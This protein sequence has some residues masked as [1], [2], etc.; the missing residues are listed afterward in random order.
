MR[1]LSYFHGASIPASATLGHVV[2][3]A[4]LV[5]A[6]VVDVRS[7]RIPNWLTGLGALLGL[8]WALLPGGVPF[9]SALGAGLAGMLLLLPMYALGIM[10]AGDAKL[11]GMA[12]TFL[13]FPDVLFALLFS[14]I[15]GGVAAI[16][17]SAWRRNLSRTLLNARDLV[18]V[19]AMSAVLGQRPLLNGFVS[20]GRLPYGLCICAGTLA[21]LAWIHFAA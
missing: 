9:T 12:G 6:T 14:L 8:V 16:A 10:G 17:Y 7:Y 20:T 4:L 21:W 13:G 11:M 3:A 19:T 18:Q 1:E 2:L 15:A 5:A